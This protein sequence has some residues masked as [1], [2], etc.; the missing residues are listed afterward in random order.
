MNRRFD[1]RRIMVT[2]TGSFGAPQSGG[3]L[4]ASVGRINGYETRSA[5]RTVRRIRNRGQSESRI[6]CVG[7]CVHR[8]NWMRAN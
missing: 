3:F 5:A 1:P 4:A 2:L 7:V 8:V 6:L